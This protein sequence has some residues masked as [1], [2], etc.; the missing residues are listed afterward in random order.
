MFKRVRCVSA[1]V[2]VLLAFGASGDL[3][4]QVSIGGGVHYLRNLGDI[5]NDGAL[6]L[7]QNSIAVQLSVRRSFGLLS[8][9]GQTGYIFNYLGTDE[10]A[11]EP[12]LWGLLGSVIY[13]G[14]GI[15]WQ[16]SN[17]EWSDKPFY[18]LRAGFDLPLG[19]LELDAYGSWR[20]QGSD[21]FEGL[22]GEDLDSLTFAA[23][24]RFVL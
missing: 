9:D 20:F 19:G 23:L 13:G 6:D 1:V 16:R 14:A 7:S 17:G 18:A 2:G 12:A 21:D 10:S 11:W 22:T 24:L 4:A 3:A 5:T 8:V 15:G